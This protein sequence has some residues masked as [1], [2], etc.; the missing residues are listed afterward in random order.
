MLLND[1]YSVL[2]VSA[3]ASDDEIRDA[4]RALVKK[5]H[6][7]RYAGSPM[8]AQAQE[9]LKEINAAYDQVQRIRSGEAP[10]PRYGGGS[11][12]GGGY[13]SPFSGAWWGAAQGAHTDHTQYTAGGASNDARFNDIREMIT[14]GLIAQ[15]EAALERMTERPA[16]WYFLRGIVHNRRGQAFNAQQC[17]QQAYN[18]EPDNVEYRNAAQRMEQAYAQRTSGGGTANPLNCGSRISGPACQLMTCCF[19]SN[20][21]RCFTC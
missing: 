9:K 5:Y 15:A 7:D 10:D 11:S 19:L 3:S 18:M 16:E 20:M 14:R 1:P 2:G 4:Y 12:S 6:P 17:F 13:G 8:E 21:C